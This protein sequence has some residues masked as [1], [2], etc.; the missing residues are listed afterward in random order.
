MGDRGYKIFP[1]SQAYRDHYEEIFGK[2][3]N[4]KKKSVD[5]KLT[6]P[7]KDKQ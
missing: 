7:K 6:K 2:V 1:R 3:D 5:D 4:K